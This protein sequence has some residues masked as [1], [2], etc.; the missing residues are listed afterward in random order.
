MVPLRL[1]TP[2]TVSTAVLLPNFIFKVF[3]A[4]FDSIIFGHVLFVAY[5]ESVQ[6]INDV[7]RGVIK[8]NPL[9]SHRL[10]KVANPGGL[11]RGLGGAARDYK[12][13]K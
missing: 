3:K 7:W 5:G 6:N 10:F 12:Y 4:N 8:V 1:P 13:D 2:K 11:C 9:L